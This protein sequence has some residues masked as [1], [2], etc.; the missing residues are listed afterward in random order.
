[1]EVNMGNKLENLRWGT[2]AGGTYVYGE[3]AVA[4]LAGKPT[5]FALSSTGWKVAP[6]PGGWAAWR[7]GSAYTTFPTK[8]EAQNYAE[9]TY[10]L[11]E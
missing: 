2:H 4:L 11:E 9:V 7:E 10:G 6:A 8:E 1:M 3:W 5:N